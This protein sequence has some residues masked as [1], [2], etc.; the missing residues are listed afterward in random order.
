MSDIFISY[1][2]EDRE[3]TKQL[4]EAL[5]RHG[6]TIWWDRKIPFGKSFDQVIEQQIS[7]SRCLI[8][9]W[10][11]HSVA[12]DWVKNEAREGKARGV[13]IPVLIEETRTPLE[14]RHI[15]T[16]N[17]VGWDPATLHP[18]FDELLREL[19]RLLGRP[20]Q[21]QQGSVQPAPSSPSEAEP[22]IS[23]TPPSV[24][25]SV[26]EPLPGAAT[27]RP[28]DTPETVVPVESTAV[29]ECTASELSGGWADVTSETARDPAKEEKRIVKKRR[30]LRVLVAA[31][32]AAVAFLVVFI[33]PWEQPAEQREVSSAPSAPVAASADQRRRAEDLYQR[34]LKSEDNTQKAKLF[35][36]SAELGHRDAQSGLGGM[37]FFGQGVAQDYA[38]ALKWH[39][40]AAEQGD[41]SSQ[42]NLGIIYSKGLGVPKNGAEAVKWF[43]KAAEMGYPSA[44][45]NL[46]VIYADGRGVPRDDAEAVKWFR[47]AAEQGFAEAQTNLGKMFVFGRGV[48]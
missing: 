9:L 32:F 27:T 48:P 34:G 18:E 40:Q 6:W 33:T 47:K 28:L 39:R 21:R 35:R 31:I 22:T 19:E 12:S 8:V 23:E 30:F 14:F 15:Q 10:S 24:S 25:A 42:N 46:G 3:R 26:Q 44:Q 13:L 45:S 1:A 37:Y 29:P 5:G 17:L 36:E 38:E 20:M 16:A 11:T 2:S 7:E 43:R 4:A 41:A